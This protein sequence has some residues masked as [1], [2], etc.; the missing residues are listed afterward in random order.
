MRV[1]GEDPLKLN[2]ILRDIKTITETIPGAVNVST[3]VQSTPL[4]FSFQFD[5]QKLQI[6]GLSLSQVALFLKMAIDG[7]DVTKVF[8]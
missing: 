7:S 3:S 4:E 2:K 5:T 6:H 1:T 8:K